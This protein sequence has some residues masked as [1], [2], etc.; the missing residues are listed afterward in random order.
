[1]QTSCLACVSEWHEPFN[2]GKGS[3]VHAKLTRQH[4]YYMDLWNSD[5]C[6]NLEFVMGL[7]EL[8][9]IN[10]PS[11]VSRTFDAWT[12]SL[13]INAMSNRVGEPSFHPED[14]GS[15]S[16]VALTHRH[17]GDSDT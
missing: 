5:C 10:I 1:M 9:G 6:Y 17:L 15:T 13:L 16:G 4:E 2:V 3:R 8:K 7:C 12:P 11:R 14:E